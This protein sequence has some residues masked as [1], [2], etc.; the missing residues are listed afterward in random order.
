M[1]VVTEELR[2]QICA[3]I[4]A[5]FEAQFGEAWPQNLMKNLRPSPLKDIALRH[6]V[7]LKTVQ[8]IKQKH[9]WLL[10]LMVEQV[11][12]GAGAAAEPT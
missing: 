9:F 7:S 2:Q 10:G 11:V 1:V 3:E 4:R 6:G 12:E 5:A 8:E